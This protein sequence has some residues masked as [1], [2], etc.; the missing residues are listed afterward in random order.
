MHAGLKSTRSTGKGHQEVAACQQPNQNRLY[1]L[2]R[3]LGRGLLSFIFHYRQAIQATLNHDLGCDRHPGRR[4]YGHGGTVH[5]FDDLLLLPGSLRC[6]SRRVLLSQRHGQVNIMRA[7]QPFEQEAFARWSVCCLPR[8][9]C[10]YLS[11]HRQM[12]KLMLP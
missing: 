1:L 9:N 8:F 3:I 11:N 6:I 4:S 7:Q 10:L 5:N 12:V 2:L